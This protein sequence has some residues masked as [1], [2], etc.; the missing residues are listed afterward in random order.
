MSL[1]FDEFVNGMQKRRQH[2]ERQT[3]SIS[4][5]MTASREIHKEKGWALLAFPVTISTCLTRE[6]S[7]KAGYF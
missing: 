4:V 1:D 5:S 2:T 7:K 3:E 6:D